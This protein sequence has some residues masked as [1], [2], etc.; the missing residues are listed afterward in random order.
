LSKLYELQEFL[1]PG[2]KQLLEHIMEIASNYHWINPQL[3]LTFVF[4][5]LEKYQVLFNVLKSIIQVLQKDNLHGCL[6]MGRLHKYIYC[7]VDAIANA[8]ERITQCFNSI[9]YRHLCNWIIYGDLVDIHNEFFIC[10]GSNKFQRKNKIR[11]PPPVRKFYINWKM[12]PMFINEDTAES[13]LFM[14]RIVWIVR[15]DPKRAT[16]DQY[17]T[18]Y[19]RDIWEGKDI[20]YYKK[21]QALEKQ[22]FD[23]VEFQRAIEEC[24]MKLTK[25]LWSVMLNEGN[26]KEHLQ[27]IRDYYALGRG[28]LF[29]QFIAV[30]ENHVKNTSSDQNAHN[31][32]FIF[33]ETARKIYGENDKTYLRF[34]LTTSK[35]ETNT[36]PWSKLQLNF[37]IN[38]PLHIVFH[39]KSMELYNKLFSYLLRLS[40][41]QI[42]L[43]KLWHSHMSGKQNIDRRV[44]TL[45]QHLIFL[46]NNLQYYLQVDV[47][48]AQFSVL[49]KAVEKANEFEDI[50]K[51]HHEF[52]SNLLAKTFVLT[53]DESHIYQNKHHLHQTPAV[54][55]NVPSKVYN[56]IIRL[57]ELCDNFC[58]IA[59]TWDA[60]LTE[61][62]VAEFEEFQ[63]RTDTIVESLLFILYRLHE[64]ANGQ[65]LLQLL[66]QLDFNRY[67]SRSKPDFNLTCGP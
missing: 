67:F 50:I 29:H 35:S 17:H 21:V 38:W 65:H 16:E 48:E 39:P 15:N 57:L 10:D 5:S 3:P 56:V 2:E 4:S 13:I 61:P 45:R 30:A 46:V 40:K 64:K 49:L 23:Q 27:L 63:K 52:I 26:L 55:F 47:I 8:A 1:H 25:Y 43:H 7:G 54:Q 34:E 36:N 42:H 51:V 28:E 31:L 58:I 53:P 6:L 18:K 12:V 32:N 62:E 37:E 33:L 41:T 9:F 11:R 60:V 66:Y 22:T 14:G 19:R 20:E 24:R 59:N 44:W